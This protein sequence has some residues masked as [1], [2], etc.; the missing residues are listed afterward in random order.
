MRALTVKQP[1]ASLIASGEKRIE[2]RSWRPPAEL[3]GQRIAIHAGASWDKRG[4]TFTAARKGELPQGR[5]VCT[6]VIDRV[7]EASDD[8]FWIGPLGWVLRDVHP[9]DDA[10]EVRGGLSLWRLNSTTWGRETTI[11][12]SGS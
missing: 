6:A 10:P 11:A 2:N 3:I 5:V 8:R 7:V 1:W 9:V 4:E 12:P